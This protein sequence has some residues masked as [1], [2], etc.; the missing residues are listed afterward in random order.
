MTVKHSIDSLLWQQLIWFHSTP[1]Q[2]NNF[3]QL[4]SILCSSKYSAVVSNTELQ[5]THT[6]TDKQTPEGTLAPLNY[7]DDAQIDAADYFG[8]HL[9]QKAGASNPCKHA[10]NCL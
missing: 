5:A 7:A 2:F 9:E 3:T 4:A 1:L 6:H 8:Y 10:V